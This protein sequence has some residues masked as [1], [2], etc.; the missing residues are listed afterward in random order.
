LLGLIPLHAAWLAVGLARRR[1]V[2]RVEQWWC[3]L[4]TCAAAVFFIY[5]LHD[6][7]WLRYQFDFLFCA[8]LA[9][10]ITLVLAMRA[11]CRIAPAAGIVFAIAVAGTCLWQAGLGADHALGLLFTRTQ[12]F[13]YW[14][15]A[16]WRPSD[17]RIGARA[18]M[19]RAA[20]FAPDAPPGVFHETETLQS[21]APS[22]WPSTIWHSRKPDLWFRADGFEWTHVAGEWPGAS[23]DVTFPQTPRSSA[24]PLFVA[25][26]D[27][28]TADIIAVR[29]GAGASTRQTVTFF[30]AHWGSFKPCES[31]PFETQPGHTYRMKVFLSHP[32]HQV[33]VTLDGEEVLYCHLDVFPH[34]TAPSFGTAMFESPKFARQFSGKITPR[35]NLPA[36]TSRQ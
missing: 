13:M 11:A 34:A 28:T 19:L 7:S 29:Y 3:L 35:E 14:D 18:Q 4:T 30:A 10:L 20:L 15:D 9:I 24:E 2:S 6:S 23:A 27:I 36:E 12:P 5:L 22:P 31:R 17:D 8:A 32:L 16:A 33:A 25:G 21:P 1:K 26:S